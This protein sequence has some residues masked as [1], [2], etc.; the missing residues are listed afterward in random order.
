MLRGEK[1]R[2]RVLSADEEVNYIEAASNIGQDILESINASQVAGL[3][4]AM[5]RAHE[6]RVAI[7][8][9]LSQTQRVVC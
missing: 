7:V 2:D 9:A 8:S 6:A 4:S 1:H 5:E 3:P